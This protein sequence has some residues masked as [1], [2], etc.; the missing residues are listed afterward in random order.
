MGPGLVRQ[1]VLLRPNSVV[2]YT[3]RSRDVRP[4][5]LAFSSTHLPLTADMGESSSH[6]HESG[7]P[8]R[9]LKQLVRNKPPSS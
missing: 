8:N 2:V 3:G 7:R 6:Y 1:E 4:R 9:C 5:K